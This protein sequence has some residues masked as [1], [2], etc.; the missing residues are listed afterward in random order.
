MHILH[1][2][3]TRLGATIMRAHSDNWVVIGGATAVP[4]AYYKR[5]AQWLAENHN[6]N[7]L[8]FDYRGIGASKDKSLRRMDAGFRDWASD[9]ECA[10]EH[11][12]DRGPTV[13]IGHSFGGHAFGMTEAHKRT[14][15]LYTF[16]TGV[17]Y[18][19]Y[20]PKGEAARVWFLWNVVAPPLVAWKG[21]LPFSKVG[22]GEDLPLGVYSDWKKWCS[23]PN[24]FFDDSEAEF[25]SNF[26]NV[27]APVVS[28][29]STDD[30]W[31][32][33]RSARAFISH[34]PNH[35]VISVSPREI[36]AKKIGHMAYVR[37]SCKPLWVNAGR[38]IDERIASVSETG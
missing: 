12:A 17:G 15:G 25:R 23:T 14:L 34:Y 30:A 19:G 5:L 9:L 24:Y 26:S 3:G 27:T 2:D 36:G 16:A 32:P 22:M 37:P 21:Y 18:H 11:A 35:E 13:V 28:V 4:H 8:T 6:V 10:I 29:N 38:W 31:A 20:M 7:V 33:P 1:P